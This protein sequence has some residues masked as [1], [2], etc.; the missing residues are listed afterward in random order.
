MRE[1]TVSH[2]EQLTLEEGTYPADQDVMRA[3]NNPHVYYH[4]MQKLTK[5]KVALIDPRPLIRLSLS[6]LLEAGS[7]AGLSLEI[8]SIFS[9][10][11]AEEL[12]SKC[13]HDF[14]EIRLV[15]LNIGNISL[16]EEEVYSKICQIKL[17]LPDI[18]LVI[19]ADDDEPHFILEVFRHGVE[20]YIPTTLSL[21]VIIQAL[22]LIYAGGIFIP[23][24]SLMKVISTEEPIKQEQSNGFKLNIL[25][26]M[27][28]RQLQVLKLL[29]QGKPNKAI[30]AELDVRESTIKAHIRYIMEKLGATNRTHA[31]FLASQLF[32]FE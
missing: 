28:P 27:T 30:A 31:A 8:L 25:E 26:G 11:N 6:H 19:F 10:S 7:S 17:K 16:K 22:R 9:F 24:D 20:G 5:I 2:L 4:D 3:S 13:S 18:P 23:A 1:A 29:W 12:L 32:T 14:H 21:P 15:I